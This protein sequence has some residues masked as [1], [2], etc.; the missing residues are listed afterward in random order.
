MI[1]I[2]KTHTR[3]PSIPGKIIME[4]VRMKISDTSFLKE[5]PILLSPPFLWEKSEPQPSLFL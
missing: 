3:T 5:L 4:R 2:N 1:E